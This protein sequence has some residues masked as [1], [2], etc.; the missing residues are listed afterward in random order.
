MHVFLT[1]WRCLV[2]K[3]YPSKLNINNQ[4]FK[5]LLSHETQLEP[6]QTLI[7]K[8]KQLE[9]EQEKLKRRQSKNDGLSKRPSLA[10]KMS[11]R[12]DRVSETTSAANTN[13]FDADDEARTTSLHLIFEW[14]CV[15]HNFYLIYLYRCI[16]ITVFSEHLLHCVSV[17]NYTRTIV[18]HLLYTLLLSFLDHGDLNY[19]CNTIP[20][21]SSWTTIT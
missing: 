21:Y 12:S 16:F 13:D 14:I 5:L 8:D 7:E 15:A 3:H 20:V 2:W 11:T 9:M 1:L 17:D 6:V 19:K 4:S 18:L 10:H